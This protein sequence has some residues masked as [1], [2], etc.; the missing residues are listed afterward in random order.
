MRAAHPETLAAT[1]LRRFTPSG[2]L[3]P[4]GLA[5]RGRCRPMP[6][7]RDPGQWGAGQWGAASRISVMFFSATMLSG[8]TRTAIAPSP[9]I[10]R[11]NSS[12]RSGPT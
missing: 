6:G 9:E 2:R 4:P 1:D 11:A 12:A 7:E 10:I 3:D 5:P 8:V